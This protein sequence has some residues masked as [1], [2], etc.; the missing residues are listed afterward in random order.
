[1]S[2]EQEKLDQILDELD[3]KGISTDPSADSTDLQ[4]NS[5][6]QPLKDD[7]QERFD[8]A[9]A[10]VDFEG[11][12]DNE[13]LEYIRLDSPVF[14]LK[15]DWL[16]HTFCG[17]NLEYKEYRSDR[18]RPETSL[19]DP[20]KMCHGETSIETIEEQL[21]NLRTTLS[22]EVDGIHAPDTNA[23]KFSVKE[24]EALLTAIPVETPKVEISSDSL[25]H[26]ISRVVEGVSNSS[27]KPREFKRSE[28][29]ALIDA[30]GGN[31]I[32]PSTPHLFIYSSDDNIKRIPI[33]TL[34]LQHRRGKGISVTSSE[35]EH[36]VISSFVA[37]PRNYLF[38]FT[39][40]G[41]VYQLE[42]HKIPV[43]HRTEQGCPIAELVNLDETEYLQSVA[44]ASDIT[45]HE[46]LTFVT[47]NGYV[48]RTK[49]TEFSNIHS[50][51]IRAIKLDEDD[52]LCEVAWSD[53]KSTVLIETRS[54]QSIRFDES[55]ARPMGRT[56]RGVSGIK[57]KNDDQVVGGG[58]I[59][60]DV[61][62][63]VLTLTERGYGKRTATM[64]YRLQTRNGSG[65]LDISTEER[66]GPVAG[67][68]IVDPNMKIVALSEKGQAIYMRV[69]E[70]SVQGRNTMGV[71][72]MDVKDDDKLV[73]FSIAESAAIIE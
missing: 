3:I 21:V 8:E 10:G 45:E 73:D 65:L 72:V 20:C 53:G 9:I 67:V 43:T 63:H 40:H 38:L 68:G 26:H 51:G 70:I 31:R 17:I 35:S 19:L 47:Q 33:D 2:D 36:A 28:M 22:N 52:E 71:Q 5:E 4:N 64:N 57:L 66:N 1:M 7:V 44:T 46:F 27:T 56:A 41:E 42:A 34:Q 61:E 24:L 30:V 50:T 48:K 23:E 54:G 62:N 69:N 29:E 14:H 58:I 49:T 15:F 11:E 6:D 37:N 59:D 12:T 60:P 18:R 39:S 13:D 32:I 55:D 25:R 16:E